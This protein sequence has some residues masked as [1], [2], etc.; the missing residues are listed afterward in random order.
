MKLHLRHVT[1]ILAVLLILTVGAEATANAQNVAS[2]QTSSLSVA[3]SYV[4]LGDSYSSGEG[5]ETNPND[6]L[7]PSSSDGCHRSPGAYPVHV[8][9]SLKSDVSAFEKQGGGF[10][11]CSG[12]STA[13]QISGPDGETSE[14]QSLSKTATKYVTVTAGGDDLP[15]SSAFEDCMRIESKILDVHAID[16]PVEPA[17]SCQAK[18]TDAKNTLKSLPAT[19]SN[20]YKKIIADTAAGTIIEVLNYPQLLPTGTVPSFCPV[21]P[22]WTL[23]PVPGITA[24]PSTWYLGLSSAVVTQFNSLGPR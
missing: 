8:A 21:T 20:Y 9:T 18:I 2:G 16:L 17:S 23:P 19:L 1:A 4:A 3:H 14:L 11:A 22:G 7:P 15:F 6:Y 12:A 5:L 13:Q 24:V 10:A